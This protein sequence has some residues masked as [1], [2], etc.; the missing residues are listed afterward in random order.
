MFIATIEVELPTTELL[1]FQELQKL[2][3]TE[4]SVPELFL[5]CA[6]EKRDELLDKYNNNIP[7]EEHKK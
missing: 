4:V 6:Y 7:S 1:K 3:N 2:T 5:S